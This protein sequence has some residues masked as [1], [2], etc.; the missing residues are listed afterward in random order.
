M[1][2]RYRP[3]AHRPAGPAS[4]FAENGS[5]SNAA[6]KRAAWKRVKAEYHPPVS[7]LTVRDLIGQIYATNKH[8]GYNYDR[9]LQEYVQKKVITKR[10]KASTPPEVWLRFLTQSLT[11]VLHEILL[12]GRCNTAVAP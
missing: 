11:F 2:I 6:T 7:K 12:A 3:A 8:L 9:Q 5:E 10:C 4:A 1:T